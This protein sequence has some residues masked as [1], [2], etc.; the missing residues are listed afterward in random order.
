MTKARGE[1]ILKPLLQNFKV[2]CV[3]ECKCAG[4]THTEWV[5]YDEAAGTVAVFS[6]SA[7]GIYNIKYIEPH[8]ARELRSLM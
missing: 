4:S 2:E 6:M 3:W 7:R 8:I 1:K 5:V